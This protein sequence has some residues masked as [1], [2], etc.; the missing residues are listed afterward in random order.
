MEKLEFKDLDR[1]FCPVSK[2]M[3]EIGDRWTLLIL[4]E[5]FWGFKRFDDFQ[6]NLKISKSV[7]TTKLN[8]MISLDLIEKQSYKEEGKRTRYEYTFTQKGKDLTKIMLSFLD[9]GNKYLVNEGEITLKA[10]DKISKKEVAI[11]ILDD[12]G[13]RLKYSALEMKIVRK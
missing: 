4:R 10:I 2:A 8:H 1:T 3:R 13:K 11:D 5:C 9:W 12:S 6:V 7:L